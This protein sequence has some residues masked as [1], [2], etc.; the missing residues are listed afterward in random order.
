MDTK[1]LCTQANWCVNTTLFDWCTH[2]FWC[3]DTWFS[4]VRLCKESN[5]FKWIVTF[6]IR[7]CFSFSIKSQKFAPS[8]FISCKC[9]MTLSI[10]TPQKLDNRQMCTDGVKN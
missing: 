4:C 2:M 5:S 3:V 7:T 6:L 10:F 1:S 9:V 8:Y